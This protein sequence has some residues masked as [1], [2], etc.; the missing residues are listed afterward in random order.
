MACVF[1]CMAAAQGAPS[2]WAVSAPA[3]EDRQALEAL[4]DHDWSAVGET[5][6]VEAAIAEGSVPVLPDLEVPADT[7]AAAL[8]AVIGEDAAAELRR[9]VHIN[10]GA[11]GLRGTVLGAPGTSLYFGQV[12]ALRYG[13]LVG[14]N[15]ELFSDTPRPTR[16]I[17]YGLA[18]QC[19]AGID[20]WGIAHLGEAAP[21]PL[22]P[23][24]AGHMFNV[25]GSPDPNRLQTFY[26]V[27]DF[28]RSLP[29]PYTGEEQLEQIYSFF[30]LTVAGRAGTDGWLTHPVSTG[31]TAECN[32]QLTLRL[33][34]GVV[35]K[36]FAFIPGDS[37]RCDTDGAVCE[38]VAV[39]TSGGPRIQVSGRLRDLAEKQLYADDYGLVVDAQPRSGAL[40]ILA[41]V[42]SITVRVDGYVVHNP[43]QLCLG[44][45][46]RTSWSFPSRAFA[47]GPHVIEVEVTDELGGMAT[48]RWSV[49]RS[50]WDPLPYEH[51]FIADAR[52]FRQDFALRADDAW[53]EYTIHETSLVPSRKRYNFPITAEEEQQLDARDTSDVAVESGT[54]TRS[55]AT[56][57]G[58]GGFNRAG[59]V[60]FAEYWWDKNRGR[61]FQ[62]FEG[63]NCTNF[64]SQAWHNGGGMPMTKGWYIKRKNTPLNPFD[65]NRSWSH[66]WS[67]VSD[68]A[69]YMT[70]HLRVATKVNARPSLPY[71]PG[72]AGD[73]VMYD[74]GRGDGFSHLALAIGTRG[75]DSD[76]IAQHS[77]DR[78]SAIWNLDWAFERNKRFKARKRTIIIRHKG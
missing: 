11:A 50:D 16:Y 77:T 74:H 7:T 33:T 32:G 69:N 28:T 20:G 2:A 71:H 62:R 35:S 56:A 39:L 46:M 14:C 76:R 68:F 13:K 64:V 48:E 22:T 25:A 24:D 54:T 29:A 72:G 52:E 27:E 42:R 73:V 49:E 3:A 66:S 40:G 34:C 8:P 12:F 61:P 53:I 55:S 26:Y 19:N 59:T 10:T 38:S 65:S 67:V 36:P 30:T 15:V 75:T 31:E 57:A 63:T 41:G 5:S 44:C 43:Q 37:V 78:F 6:A 60:S 58:S 18:L 4:Y 1:G 47:A 23:L 45:G 17:H 51:Q 21:R 9:G 70:E